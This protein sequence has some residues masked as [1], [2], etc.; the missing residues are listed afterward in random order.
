MASPEISEMG[1]LIGKNAWSNVR[2]LKEKLV[3]GI[4]QVDARKVGEH[5]QV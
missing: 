4:K 3:L 2:R 5:D 1:G